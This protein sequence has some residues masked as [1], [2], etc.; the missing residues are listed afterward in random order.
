MDGAYSSLVRDH[1]EN[2]RHVGSL[3]KPDAEGRAENPITGAS[4]VLQ[5]A[6]VGRTIQ[7][8]VFRSQGC[9]ATIACGSVMTVLLTGQSVE[10]AKEI[11]RQTVADALGGLPPTRKHA[12]D[13]AEEALKSALA[14]LLSRAS[15]SQ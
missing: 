9:A 3:C 1:F 5:L 13:L 2:P 8:A 10:K 4:L 12:A 7:E 15:F 14:D 11:T 6:V